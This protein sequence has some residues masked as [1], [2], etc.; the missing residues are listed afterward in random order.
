MAITAAFTITQGTDN[1]KGTL[2]D[3]TVYSGGEPIAAMVSRSVTLYKSDGTV[4]DTVAFTG[5]QTTV[6]VEDL[7]K[8][9]SVQA[10]FTI[11]PPTVE[12][13]STY[14]AT[15]YQSF[16]GYSM[17]AFYQ[18]H[19]RQM[20]NL[21]LEANAA[22]MLDNYKILM[23]VQASERASALEDIG[24]AQFCLDRIYKIYTTNSLP[25]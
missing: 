20:V 23:E 19:L 16:T 14:T 6:D 22:Y 24:S 4:L 1:S 12:G 7:V 18:R 21:R 17:T 9:Y 25:Y 8:D 5:V 15:I 11:T 2:T 13:G 10:V 3:T